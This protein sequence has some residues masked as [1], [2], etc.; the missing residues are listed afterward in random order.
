MYTVLCRAAKVEAQI[1]SRAKEDQGRQCD[2]VGLHP[3]SLSAYLSIDSASNLAKTHG[4]EYTDLM[5]SAT[6]GPIHRTR[7]K[8]LEAVVETG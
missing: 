4:L 3:S 1:P 5:N 6:Y 2:I 7:N 8:A